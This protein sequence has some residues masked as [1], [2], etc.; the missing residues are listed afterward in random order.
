[1]SV[2]T[3]RR[4]SPKSRSTDID[5]VDYRYARR[6]HWE[7]EEGGSMPVSYFLIGVVG[8]LA[9]IAAIKLTPD[10]IRYMKIRSM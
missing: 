9:V 4:Q 6:R 5:G 2:E 3:A 1:M 10:F 8:V 7:T